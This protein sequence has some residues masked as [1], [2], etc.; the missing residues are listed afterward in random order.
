M[1][2]VEL[3]TPTRSGRGSGLLGALPL[4]IIFPVFLLCLWELAA[5]IGLI[6]V[7]FFPAPTTVL[8]TAA[9]QIQTA[10]FWGDLAVSLQRIAIG[11]VMGAIPGILVGLAMGLFR[12]VH[13]AL[14]PLFAAI[15]P[16][17]KIALLPLLL[18]IFGIGE[19]S[20]YVVIAINVFFLMTLNTY[21]G[22]VGIPKIYF[23]VAKNLKASRLTTYLTV[24]LPGALP[25]IF[26]GLRICMG[27]ALILLV[28][29]EFSTADSGVGYRIWW[30]WTVFWVD[31]MY[32]GFLVIAVLGL[33][34][35]YLLDILEKLIVPW[36]QQR[37]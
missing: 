16:I 34:F 19:T 28:A 23:E 13:E 14:N 17:P 1:A 21:A 33:A 12:P 20:K 9:A 7:A 24:A 30:A 35:S 4:G 26:T 27:T 10:Q 18:L 5:R 11:L 22:V 2:A 37:Q 15:F 31:T 3:T 25:G 8:A 36:R 32:V 6:N 29:V